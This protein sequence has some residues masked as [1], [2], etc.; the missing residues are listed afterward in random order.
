MFSCALCFLFSY[1]H[2]QTPLPVGL[3]DKAPNS[4]AS[5][6]S[7]GNQGMYEKTTFFFSSLPPAPFSLSFAMNYTSANCSAIF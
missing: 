7:A 3:L 4:S 6:A 2:K 1:Q 5:Q